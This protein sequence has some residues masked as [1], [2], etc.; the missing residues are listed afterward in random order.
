MGFIPE[1]CDDDTTVIRYYYYY[2]YGNN[3]NNNTDNNKEN[4]RPLTQDP[5]KCLPWIFSVHL[6]ARLH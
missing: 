1:P 2:Y 6:V 5:I 4:K 3:G